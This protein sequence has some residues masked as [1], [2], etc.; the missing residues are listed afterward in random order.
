MS[1]QKVRTQGDMAAMSAEHRIA[2]ENPEDNYRAWQRNVADSLKEK[3]EEE[4]RQLL[5]DTAN[6]F[7][8]CFEHWLGDFNMATGVRNA[9]GFNA[10][11]VF[12]IGDRK[13]D[14]RAA[15]GVHNYTEIQWIPTV[16]DLE[17]LRDKYVFVGIDNVPGSVPM[18]NY[19]WPENTMM[20]FGEEGPGL[21]PAMQALC[22]DI[23]HIEMFGS[24][25]SFNCGSASAVAMYDFVSKYKARQ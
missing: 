18:A 21:T 24:V 9:N 20:I 1:K 8:V 5:R 17:A 19:E 13:W 16:S 22:K 10:K 6:P 11:E 2:L 23:V 25:R 15:V 4:I 14:R 12:Y 7:A 3:S